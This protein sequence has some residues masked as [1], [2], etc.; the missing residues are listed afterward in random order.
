MR[1]VLLSVAIS[2]S[3]FVQGCASTAL[4]DEQPKPGP[5]AS[6]LPTFQSP[7]SPEAVVTEKAEPQGDLSL[8]QALSMSLLHNPQLEASAWQ[9]SAS[10]AAILQ[11]SLSPNPVLGLKVENFGGEGGLSEFD[12]AVTTLRISQAIELG[13]KRGK[14]IRLA[15]DQHTRTAW[16]YEAQRLSVIEQ[17]GH[18]Y[19]DVLSGQQ[20][21]A[22]AEQA[23]T[24]A[25]DLNVIVKD[26]TLQGVTP[27][28]ELDKTLVQVTAREIDLETRT[29]Q[30]KTSRQHL[31]AMWGSTS[32]EFSQLTGRLTEVRD[33]PA[34]D[35]L[36]QL[37]H[38]NPDIARWTAEIAS[39][40]AAVDVSQA[41]GI[42]NLTVGGGMRRFNATDQD[43]YVF[44]LGLP[45]P[46]V[47]RNQGA[48]RQAR[49]NLLQAKALKRTAVT[50][51]H[52]RL[53]EL[54]NSLLANHH[55]V[56]AL[57]DQALPAARS[58]FDAAQKA[59]QHGVTD[60]IN[61]LDA[62]RTLINTQYK[63]IDSLAMYHKTLITLEA[64]LGT[65]VP[66]E[67]E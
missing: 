40:K 8:R 37:V 44:E 28:S 33:A 67:P 65:P 26:R 62:E 1:L 52:T 47:D 57:R 7:K 34:L 10:E 3:L 11:S 20:E 42:P 32:P 66:R 63:Y 50:A 46:L 41:K 27:T 29:Q 53:N 45:L 23:L 9:L 35:D 48:R 36:M 17:T 61:V 24:L 4:T 18:R 14:R 39:R 56:T 21:Q 51:V 2:C 25:S 60:Y 19:I 64:F 16:D 54:H 12:S 15:Q 31:A 22:L 43:A 55:A 5:L 6:D 30:L 59:F 58:A 13:G 49:F 38:R